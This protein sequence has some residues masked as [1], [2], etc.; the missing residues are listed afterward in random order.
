MVN[1]RLTRVL[2]SLAGHDAIK[3][4]L[5]RVDVNKFL[6]IKGIKLTI[7]TPIESD[8]EKGYPTFAQIAARGQNR[9]RRLTLCT[10][11]QASTEFQV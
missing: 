10:G 4:F 11:T 7:S 1:M 9:L 5:F 6:E 2:L 8:N 3:I